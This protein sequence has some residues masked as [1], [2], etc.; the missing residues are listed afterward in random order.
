MVKLPIK[1]FIT[2]ILYNA[3][4]YMMICKL[5]HNKSII[6]KTVKEMMQKLKQCYYLMDN[7]GGEKHNHNEL[8]E[9]IKCNFRFK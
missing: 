2:R 5:K 8:S 9:V 4:Y 7:K 3:H 6:V 1:Q